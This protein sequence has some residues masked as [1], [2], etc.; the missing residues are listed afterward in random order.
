[1]H[2]PRNVGMK[3]ESRLAET[4]SFTRADRA[5]A[6]LKYSASSSMPIC[7][8]PV[9]K[10]AVHVETWPQKQSSTTSPGSEYRPILRTTPAFLPSKGSHKIGSIYDSRVVGDTDNTP[11]ARFGSIMNTCRAI[12]FGPTHFRRICRV[13]CRVLTASPPMRPLKVGPLNGDGFDALLSRC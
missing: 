7:L 13:G 1:M 9:S 6:W 2:H 8:R 5:D 4:L 11:D 12:Q 3:G 10:A